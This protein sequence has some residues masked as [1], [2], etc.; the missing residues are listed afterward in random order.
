MKAAAALFAAANFAPVMDVLVSIAR[1]AVRRI[2]PESPAC[3][4]AGASWP[5][6]DTVTAPRS[7]ALSAGTETSSET[8]PGRCSKWL[9]RA[10]PS[11]AYAGVRPTSASRT[12]AQASSS[13]R[14]IGSGP[15]RRA[16]GRW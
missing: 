3:A 2:S 6:I 1:I 16:A 11:A 13:R 4:V 5:A 7:T 10:P 15:S 12:T 8:P 9:I 14:I